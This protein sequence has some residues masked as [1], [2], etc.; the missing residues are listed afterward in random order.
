MCVNKLVYELWFTE[1][2]EA[3]CRANIAMGNCRI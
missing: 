1:L 2:G 3:I